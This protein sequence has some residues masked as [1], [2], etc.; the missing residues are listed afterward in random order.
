[1]ADFVTPEIETGTPPPPAGVIGV[2]FFMRQGLDYSTEMKARGTPVTPAN[3]SGSGGPR[4]TSG[5]IWPR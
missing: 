3:S 4:P 5:L 1:M 2:P